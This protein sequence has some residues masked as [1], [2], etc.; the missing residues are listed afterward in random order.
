MGNSRSAYQATYEYTR[1]HQYSEKTANKILEVIKNNPGISTAELLDKTK[2]S[3]KTIGICT[4]DFENNGV[5]NSFQRKI[6]GSKH[7]VKCFAFSSSEPSQEPVSES[8]TEPEKEENEVERYPEHKRV[9]QHEEPCN[10]CLANP[11]NEDSHKPILW[12]ETEKNGRK[13]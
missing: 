11:V 10:T 8:A 7:T 4:K 3:S 12:E 13:R 1:A 5:L 6:A 2:L 9:S